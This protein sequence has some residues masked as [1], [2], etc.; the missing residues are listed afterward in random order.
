MIFEPK[1][2]RLNWAIIQLLSSATR[3]IIVLCVQKQ[4]SY[5]GE[6]IAEI[7]RTGRMKYLLQQQQQ[8]RQK[9]HATTVAAEAVQQCTEKSNNTNKKKERI[10][11]ISALTLT[12]LAANCLLRLLCTQQRLQ[13]CIRRLCLHSDFFFSTRRT[14]APL[15]CT[16]CA[17]ITWS[18]VKAKQ[19]QR[20]TNQ[21]KKK[22]GSN[23]SNHKCIKSFNGKL[24]AR[25]GIT[26][27]LK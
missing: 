22:K 13:S 26:Y 20:S 27:I 17:A 12:K 21:K 23:T 14:L 3:S 2:S 9:R 5:V 6:L 25:R 18:V 16:C 7:A 15:I 4:K 24:H 10:T 8:Q 19:Q 1:T 11:C